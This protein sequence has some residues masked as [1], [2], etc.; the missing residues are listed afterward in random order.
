MQLLVCDSMYALARNGPFFLLC[1]VV[2]LILN[3]N[4]SCVGS[5]ELRRLV[6]PRTSYLGDLVPCHCSSECLL[7]YDVV[8]FGINTSEEF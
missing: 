4:A 6:L 2:C 1:C 8:C 5:K 3:A 7:R